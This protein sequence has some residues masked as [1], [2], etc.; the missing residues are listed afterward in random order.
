MLQA[1]PE[2]WL[3]HFQRHDLDGVTVFVPPGLILNA[4]TLTIKAVGVWGLRW[5]QVLGVAP[6]AACCV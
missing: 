3:S 2:K 5:L 6:V 4:R 1:P